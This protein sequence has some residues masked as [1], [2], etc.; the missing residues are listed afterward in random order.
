M[1]KLQIFGYK[2]LDALFAV[3]EF[4]MELLEELGIL[5]PI[6]VSI[7][8]VLICHKHGWII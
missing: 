8:T 4:T 7:A 3:L 5:V 2:L 6:A 1:S